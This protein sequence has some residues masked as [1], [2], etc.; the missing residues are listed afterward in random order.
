[1]NKLWLLC[2]LLLFTL[3]INAQDDMHGPLIPY[4]DQ[5]LFLNGINL[6]WMDF[7][8]DLNNFNEVRF[9]AA[10]DEL[11]AA[12]GNTLRWWLHTNG[13]DSPLYDEDG[14]VIGLGENELENLRRAL[15]LAYERGILIMPTLWSH[16]MMNEVEGVPIDAN[17][18]MIED[19][20]YT[21]A[22]IDNAL[23][24]MIE[25]LAGHPAII[26]WEIFNEPE[27]TTEEYGWTD[28]R[29]TMPY[30]QQFVNLLA[31][32]I[33]RADPQALVTNGSWNIRVLTD[34]NGMTNYYT[35]ER[36]IEAGGDPDGTLDFYQV[37]YYPEHFAENESPFHNPYSHWELDKPLIVGEF[38]AAGLYDMGRGYLPSRQ[39]R[40][41]MLT[42]ENLY[43]N[44]YA[45]ALSWTFYESEFG[46]MF[47]ATP[48]ILRV[49]N[50]APGHVQVE[51]G[52]IDRIPVIQQAIERLVVNNG[53]PMLENA[54]NLGDVFNDEEDGAELTYTITENSLPDVV[55]AVIDEQ[56]NVSLNF[57][58]G[59]TGT[60]MIEITATDSSDN[61]S[62][63]NFVVQVV[64]PSR[65]N[66]A[67][68]K[69]VIASSLENQGYPAP[70]AVDGLEN[71]RWASA[72]E[73]EQYLDVDLG[74]VFTI[75]Q[76]IL[77]W[78]AAY[79]AVYDIQV[80]DGTAWLTVYSEPDGDG[81]VDDI[82]LS[83]PVDTRYVRFNGVMRATQWGF[84]LWEFE[85]YGTATETGDN[86]L[87]TQ[88]PSFAHAPT[89]EVEAV[90]TEAETLYSY[91]TDEEGFVIVDFWAGGLGVAVADAIA[92]DGEQSLAVTSS[93][94][95]TE[96]AE[97]GAMLATGGV[98]WSAYDTL[99]V[100]VFVPEG[101]EN[102]LSQIFIQTGEDWTWANT[103]DIAL[104]AG[105]WTTVTANLA[106]LG[107]MSLVQQFGVKV[108]TSAMAFEGEYYV[109]NW[110][111][112]VAEESEA[113]VEPV[114]V[115]IDA[116]QS[117]S[118]LSENIEQY[119]L[120]E[121]EVA[122]EATFSNP[123]DP[124][125]IRLDGRFTS[126][127][128]ETVLV[129]GFFYEDFEYSSGRLISTGE[130]SWR[131]RFT[132]QEA[133]NY[134][135]RIIATTLNGTVRSERGTFT[136]A[137]SDHRGFVRVDSRNPRYFAFD[138]GS[139]YFPVG[140]NMAW[141][142]DDTIADFSIWLDELRESGGN[143]I[144]VWMAPWDMNIEWID[145]GLGDYSNRMDRAYEL[146]RVIE[147][148]AERDIYIM[149]TLLNHGQFNETVDPEWNQNPYNAANGGP[150]DEPACFATD[151]EAIRYW[152]QR[153]RYIAARWG[154]S[155]NIMTWEFWN[156]INWT[157][158]VATDLL[159]PWMERSTIFLGNLDPYDHLFTHSGSPIGD[160]EVW[161]ES[162]LD[163]VQ[164]HRYNMD[165]VLVTFNQVIPEWLEMYPDQPFLMG[166]F[167]S[168]V[169][170]DT[171][172]VLLHQGIWS[173]P[174][175][176]AAGTAMTWW[177]E[178]LVHP[179]DLW[180]ELFV[181]VSAY[182]AGED[183]ATQTWQPI[184][185]D[186]SERTRTRV[187][188]L[189]SED[190]ALVWVVSRDYSVTYLENAYN[191]FVRDQLRA[192]TTAN[193]E[194]FTVEFPLVED[195]ILQIHALPEGDYTVEFW[196]TFTGEMTDTISLTSSDGILA[197]ALPPFNRDLA[198]KIKPDA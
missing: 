64:D 29:T 39:Y 100:D 9:V 167:G 96:W 36:L 11:A 81:Q 52:D 186:F 115:Q 82:A 48:G 50:L 144:R 196:D 134:T 176:G 109:D 174:M 61:Y 88:P 145:T 148:A 124:N 169:E 132:P 45:G 175:N 55:E 143:F 104:V 85:I 31:G 165:D 28:R 25:A 140:L 80:W 2:V 30:I 7:A 172:N 120:V 128:G 125:E 136:V 43:E 60:A 158:L 193:L 185:A 79:G 38:P 160:T 17:Q 153:L 24:P 149:L 4:N 6:A 184:N 138:D 114:Q 73:D 135:Y 154:Y 164:D 20:E 180:D 99:S 10:L 87:E 56:H 33:H 173:A 116:I 78:E 26:A 105:E 179:N 147:M 54:F 71:T 112:G 197:I 59:N 192:G 37:H 168:P 49:N 65:G 111:L 83:E 189:Q 84:S 142:T 178:T 67:V 12:N 194:D 108:G 151:E 163:I 161:A 66:V 123:F 187:Y 133:G 51:L 110:R 3:P 103:G 98:D 181:G 155:P 95:G 117:V 97:S 156:E 1:M 14:Y 46:S 101:S 190:T 171:E 5:Q 131:V 188:G 22:Y 146:D 86:V 89:E 191:G 62:R 170:A 121:L 53:V 76:V 23:I 94:S 119:A 47:E 74:G 90:I 182:F 102:L 141:S 44:G 19:P 18:R 122:M 118:I 77:R 157:P 139:P 166:E 162:G 32:A 68:G 40:N 92:S 159:A 106:D 27:G 137:E 91:E 127:S 63:I 183:L 15:D 41:S 177:W 93:F 8:R 130:T 70:D 198:L 195:I 42:Y 129:P 126:P 58:S 72:Y 16:D 107:D 75:S 13:S 113:S 57:G 21:Q 69:T 152:N 34:V 150:C 35:D